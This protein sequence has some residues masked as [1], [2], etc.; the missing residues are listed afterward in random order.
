MS[1]QHDAGAVDLGSATGLYARLSTTMRKMPDESAGELLQ[2]LDQ[3]FDGE[4]AAVAEV[5]KLGAGETA[6]PCAV[7]ERLCD[8]CAHAC[9]ADGGVA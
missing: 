2:E 9:R 5:G 4:M 3:L 6:H 8:G 7:C 1:V